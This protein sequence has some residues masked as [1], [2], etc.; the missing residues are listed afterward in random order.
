MYPQPYESR[1]VDDGASFAPVL[2]RALEARLAS[3]A[4]RM[5][6]SD[7]TAALFPYRTHL[8]CEIEYLKAQLA[9]ERRR[10]DVLVEQKLIPQLGERPLRMPVDG[11]KASRFPIPKGWDA[12]RA[13][14]RRHAEAEAGVSPVP[15]GVQGQSHMAIGGQEKAQAHVELNMEGVRERFRYIAER[16]REI[17]KENPS[18]ISARP[19]AGSESG[20]E[21]SRATA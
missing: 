2:R 9:Q 16:E 12:T 3:L 17:A 21:D 14:E 10:V 20:T 6:L 8:E 1:W 19:D 5:K 4:V 11:L 13:E 15:S 18:F 7:L